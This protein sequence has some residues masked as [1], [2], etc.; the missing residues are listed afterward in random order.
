MSVKDSLFK[1]LVRENDLQINR[2]TNCTHSNTNFE[3][4]PE[5]M[6]H[7]YKIGFLNQSNNSGTIYP[8]FTKTMYSEN[9]FY[10]F[11]K[12]K[13]D[14]SCLTVK[15]HTNFNGGYSARITVLSSFRLLGYHYIIDID[16]DPRILKI[17]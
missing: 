8:V 14:F 6:D 9:G 15:I 12:N 2:E 17:R 11:Y 10:D 5:L 7:C 1:V 4:K 13:C 3:L 16:K